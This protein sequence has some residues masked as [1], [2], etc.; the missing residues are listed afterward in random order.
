MKKKILTII[1]ALLVVLAGYF[2][3]RKYIA[4]TRIALVNFISYQAS[5]IALSNDDSFIKFEEVPLDKLDQL[6]KYD[7]VL[8]WAMGLKINDQQ[9]NQLI[10]AANR[11][12]FHSFAVTNPDNDISSL[13]EAE[14]KKVGDYLM[15]GNKANYQNLARYIRKY[16]VGKWFATEPQPPIE[17][18]ENVYFH[19]DDERSFSSLNEYEE[20]IKKNNFYKEGAPRIAIVAGLHEPFG[21]NKEH[22][23]G[24]IKA[25]QQQGMNVFPFTAQAKRIEFLTEINPDAIVYF[26][27][28]QMMMGQ[29]EL[30]TSWAKK[31]NI[32]LFTGLSILSMKADW[33]KDP[34]GMSG[35]FMGQTI[36]M[37]EL[38]GALYPYV[39]IAQEQ[40]KQGYYFLNA[41]ENRAQKFAKIIHNFTQLKHKAN[42][43]KKLAIVYFKG[44]GLAP[45]AAQGLEV[46]PSLYRFLHQLQAQ[47]YNVGTLPPTL[48]QFNKLLISH[49][50]TFRAN[51]KGD[52]EKFI[53]TGAPA[54][55]EATQLDGWMKNTL[56]QDLY[57]QVLA[58]NGPVPGNYLSTTKDG[59][60]YLAVA[61]LTFGNVTIL[62]Q[63]PAAISTDDDFKVLHGVQE[64]P[65]YAYIGAYLWVQNGLKADALIHFG[66]H[67]SLEFTPNKQV[68]LSD[69][70]WADIS[71]GTVPHFYYYSIGNIGEAMM[72]KRRS[73]GSIVSYL[74]PAFT[75]SD[76]RNTF[77]TLE[78]NILSYHKAK[79]EIDKQS[80]GLH[81][82]KL[83]VQMGLHRDLRLDSIVTKPYTEEEIERLSNF[84]EEI[85]TE[86]INGEFYVMGVPYTPDKINSTLLAMSA[87]PI[88]YSVATLDKYKGKI[89][90]KDL[91]NRSFFTANY[92]NPAKSLV[93]QILAGKPV[94]TELVCSYAHITADELQKA[95]EIM[96]AESGSGMP[97][98]LQQQ[99]KKQEATASSTATT[100]AHKTD[101][102]GRPTKIKAPAKKEERKPITKEELAELNAKK[103]KVD[104][105][106]A[107]VDIEKTIGNVMQYKQ[108]LLESPQAE[109]KA[110]F[111]ALNGGYTPPSSGGDAV[112]NPKGVPT[113]RNLYGVNAES[114]PSKLAWDRGMALA[115]NV[116]AEYQKKHNEYPKKIAYTFWSSEFIETEGVSIAQAL[117]MLGVEPVWDS[118]GRVGDVRVIPSEELGRPRID[119]VIQ[120]SGQFRDLA[121][122]RLFLLNKA[123]QM[124]SELPEEAFANQVSEGSVTIEKELVAAGISPKE[125]RELSTE[126]IFGGLQGRYDTGIKEMINAGDKWE[127]T[128]DIAEVYMHNMGALYSSK[129]GWS[130][131][132]EGMFRAAIKNADVLI[133]PRQNNTWGA[134]SLDH[135]Y[136]FMGGMNA[137]IREVNGK[138]PDAYLADYRNHKNMRMQELKEAVGVEAR[139][140]IF[141]P[142]YIKEMMKGKASSA[143]QIAEIV[144]NMHGWEATRPE[145]I[146]DAM[147]NEVYDTYIEDKQKLGVTEFIKKE[148]VAALQEVTAVMLELTRK[149]LWKATDAQIS[150]LA[151]MHTELTEQFGVS[152]SQFSSENKKLQD[153]ISKKVDATKAQAYQQQIA[154]SKQSSNA[155]ESKQDAK[156][157]KKEE[158][159]LGGEQ[160]KVSLN[161]VWIG[162]GVLIAFVGL[163]V[164]IRK[165]RRN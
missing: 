75:E 124:V 128:K 101:A 161:T 94:T 158:T 41:I 98:F 38:D 2:V 159:T 140:T 14:Q 126:R 102:V 34:M 26:P 42:A 5:N 162:I 8:V 155:Q 91:K 15:S 80:I 108:G 84:A 10:D 71:V 156:V 150:K 113:G 31:Q 55:V 21:G 122:S 89:T 64:I 1:A 90:E 33:E 78:N 50:S 138:E 69:Y 63:P 141:N 73:Y 70:D 49:A 104:Y 137:A 130:K 82:K 107:L 39:V 30:F 146:D 116:I 119:V 16:I 56:P 123:I 109:E 72:A 18:K 115:Q 58:K 17:R 53:A 83:A 132:Q 3:W 59:K 160:E 88:A 29:P 106:R 139:S 95:K 47:G 86:K 96:A 57:K 135:V 103:A 44:V 145:L 81:I 36:V 151:D 111:N 99:M 125:A 147:W 40:N 37:P 62:P 93:N 127:N 66:T 100:T 32:P 131:F 164:F 27:H 46:E 129:E 154:A 157:L 110:F 112:A 79:N 142:K 68:A 134:L 77:N 54:L 105:A 92:L 28:G 133:Q 87:D 67:G 120:T 22:L 152:S 48:E 165:R 136:E 35:G 148:N 11:V 121:A 19:L 85:A 143:G 45:A 65:P 9:R 76:M 43:D 7:F 163:I 117:Y 4:P 149:G 153:Y 144:T 20:Y 97:Y 52:I 6:K 23:N 118:F 12:P 114:T 24:V 60:N 61:Q 51:A 13:S 74:T 25:L